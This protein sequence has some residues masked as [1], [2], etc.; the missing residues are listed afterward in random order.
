VEGIDEE[1]L[2]SLNFNK[3]QPTV[4][5]IETGKFMDLGRDKK[6][7]VDKFMIDKNYQVIFYNLNN[8]IYIYKPYLNDFMNS[9]GVLV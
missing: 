1:I 5:C 7:R 3:H 2:H 8:T 6:E 4:V 9:L